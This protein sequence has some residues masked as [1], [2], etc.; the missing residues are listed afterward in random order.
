MS[1]LVI[2]EDRVISCISNYLE[3]LDLCLLDATSKQVSLGLANWQ[4]KPHAWLT[5]ALQVGLNFV[6]IEKSCIKAAFSVMEGHDFRADSITVSSMKGAQELIKAV[7]L[8]KNLRTRHLESSGVIAISFV[9]YLYF[10][11][12]DL[13]AYRADS[14]AAV[15]SIPIMIDLGNT[16]TE[17]VFTWCE[18]TMWLSTHAVKREPFMPFSLQ[19]HAVASPLTMRKY[20]TVQK[21][22]EVQRGGGLCCTLQKPNAF[23]DTM[24]AGILCTGFARSLNSGPETARTINALHL[25]ARNT[26]P[27]HRKGSRCTL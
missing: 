13:E 3:F 25:E 2:A 21:P 8:V 17:M 24:Q 10:P 16:V 18:E 11:A 27:R 19:L 7:Q 12:R 14:E 22:Q 5:A 20:F 6:G 23:I 4:G 15:S 1:E 9:I 26:N